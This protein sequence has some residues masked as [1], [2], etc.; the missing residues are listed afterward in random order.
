MVTKGLSFITSVNL[1]FFRYDDNS[2][3]DILEIKAGPRLVLGNFKRNYFD[4][5]ELGLFPR[6]KFNRGESPFGFDQVVDKK[7][8]EFNATQHIFSA[9]AVNFKG[10]LNISDQDVDDDKFINPIIGLSWNRR[11]Y[12]IG[13]DYNFN[14]QEGGLKFNIYSFNFNGFGREF[15]NN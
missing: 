4:Y 6:F 8:I 9:L 2:K 5:T 11:A 10:E 3:Q 15:K 1:D 12:K 13:V 7:V 14:T